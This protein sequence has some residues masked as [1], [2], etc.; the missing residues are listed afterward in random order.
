MIVRYALSGLTGAVINL[1]TLSV[2]YYL[3]KIYYITSS[4]I[5]FLTASFIGLILH[6]F[7]TFR[8]RSLSEA[9]L[10]AGKYLLTSLFALIMNTTLLYVF[11]DYMHFYVFAG[12]IFASLIV[13]GITFFISRDHVF[14]NGE[15]AH[16]SKVES[17][18]SLKS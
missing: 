13:A 12:Q 6:K 2:L 11:V 8:D 17:A 5:A 7:W 15:Y 3:F 9:H 14:T 16:K 4:V 10:Q 18:E 1:T